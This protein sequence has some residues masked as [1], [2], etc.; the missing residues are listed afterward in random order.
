[1]VWHKIPVNAMFTDGDCPNYCENMLEMFLTA[2]FKLT[3]FKNVVYISI[4]GNLL[5]IGYLNDLS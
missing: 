4:L 2:Q 3:C 5:N 1:M